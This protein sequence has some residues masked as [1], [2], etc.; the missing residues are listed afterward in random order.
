MCAE[1]IDTDKGGCKD[2]VP[3]YGSCQNEVKT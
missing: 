1:V 3:N 2:V